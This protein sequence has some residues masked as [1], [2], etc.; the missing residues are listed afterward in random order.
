M[1]YKR[2]KS[3]P[4]YPS[5]TIAGKV[6]LE[7]GVNQI[8]YNAPRV[9]RHFLNTKCKVGDDVTITITRKRATRTLQQNSYYHMYVDLISLSSGHSNEEI[10]AW[11]KGKILSKGITE[12][13][14]DKVR[15]VESTT[16]LG[17][18]EFCEFVNRLE[19]LTGVPLPDPEPFNLPLTWD[20][21]KK[22]KLEQR[23]KYQKV[24]PKKFMR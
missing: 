22:L 14:G 12:V 9:L 19:E 5:Q 17:I 2:K 6:V 16:A 15:I 18:S 24:K 20:E 4:T 23:K 8:Q 13:F 1:K 10:H 7:S 3:V 21:H 11:A